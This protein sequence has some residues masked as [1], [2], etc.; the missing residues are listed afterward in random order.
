MRH[1]SRS[2]MG[3]RGYDSRQRSENNQ[4]E[5][6]PTPYSS[7]SRGQW[8]H[9]D[10][11]RGGSQRYGAYDTGS[12]PDYYGRGDSGARYENSGYGSQNY[13][14]GRDSEYGSSRGGRESFG[15]EYFGDQDRN[16][17]GRSSFG[18]DQGTGFGQGEFGGGLRDRE[19]YGRDSGGADSQR[20]SFAGKGPKGYK[21]SD[22]RIRE[23]VSECLEADHHIDAS[24]VEVQVK[25]G[26]VTLTGTVDSRFAKRHAEEIIENLRGVKDVTN[27]IQVQSQSS[28]SSAS[29]GSRTSVARTDSDRDE[30]S[31]NGKARRQ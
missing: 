17:Q 4:Q 29:A 27:Q 1:Q 7:T 5:F 11:R 31:R 2:Q 16:R 15:N 12:H 30:D 9:E 20:R 24:E 8:P 10:G 28:T 23:D 25:E 21:R 18:A 19:S 14:Y 6:E 26:V 22:E 13:N 3:G